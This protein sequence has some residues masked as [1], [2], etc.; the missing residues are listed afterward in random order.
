M[1]RGV[2]DSPA[3]DAATSSARPHSTQNFAPASSGAPH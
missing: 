1:F 2:P 3:P